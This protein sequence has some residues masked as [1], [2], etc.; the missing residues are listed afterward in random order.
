MTQTIIV[1]LPRRL[2]QELKA[3]ARSSRTT[4]SAILRR[5]A[6]EYVRSR[7]QTARLNRLQKHILSHA[8]RWDGYC[9]GEELLRKTRR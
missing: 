7:N 1:R 3:D 2:V 4:P 5:M 9:S 6:T 8:G